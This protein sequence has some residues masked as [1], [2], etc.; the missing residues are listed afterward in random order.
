MDSII[1]QLRALNE[2]VPK[3]PRLPSLD[4]IAAV[5]QRF[6]FAFHSDYKQFLLEASDVVLGTLEPT[7]IPNDSGHTFIGSVVIDARQ[8]GLPSNL[9]PIAEDNGDYYC[10]QPTGE[11]VFW[12]HDGATE[13]HWPDLATW[14]RKVWI[15]VHA[16]E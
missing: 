7:T 8:Q 9:V 15:G 6:G 1:A 14:I 11:V 3:P 13:E 10:M 2:P 12:S 4:E 5:E 16:A